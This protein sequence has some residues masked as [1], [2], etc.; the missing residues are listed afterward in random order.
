[1]VAEID[2]SNQISNSW[3]KNTALAIVQ[4]KLRYSVLLEVNHKIR[5]KNYCENLK[6]IGPIK[7]IAKKRKRAFNQAISIVH[8]YL[9]YKLLFANRNAVKEVCI[10]A[11][12]QAKYI[13]IAFQNI[14]QN[15]GISHLFQKLKIKFGLN[16]GN[17]VQKY[18]KAVAQG[19]IPAT[20][21]LSIKD[22]EEILSLLSKF[23]RK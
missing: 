23:I 18:V 7:Y 20:Y 11:D 4:D 21:R 3:N 15:L 1:M 9:V 16:K 5:V 14:T 22:I 17:Q 12:S 2:M 10:C 8:A 19:Q 6:F 13:H